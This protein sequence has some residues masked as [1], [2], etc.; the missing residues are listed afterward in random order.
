MDQHPFGFKFGAYML[1]IHS[2]TPYAWQ[3]G[4]CPFLV[5]V[6]TNVHKSELA[7]GE[8]TLRL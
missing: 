3:T 1:T 6:F 5:L 4:S 8:S 7:V 2:G